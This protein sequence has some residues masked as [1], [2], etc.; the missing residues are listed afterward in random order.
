MTWQETKYQTARAIVIFQANRGE[1]GDGDPCVHLEISRGYH[2]CF[3]NARDEVADS[4]Q[5]RP[6]QCVQF[7]EATMGDAWQRAFDL[8][9]DV[10]TSGAPEVQIVLDDLS[11]DGLTERERGQVEMMVH[12]IAREYRVPVVTLDAATP[13]IRAMIVRRVKGDD[14]EA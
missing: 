13:S 12:S 14:Y 4:V 6:V 9:Y 11:R 7:D 3:P 10:V 5:A 8:A 1:L 2:F